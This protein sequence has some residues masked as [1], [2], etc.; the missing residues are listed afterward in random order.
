MSFFT[1]VLKRCGIY[2]GL[3][4]LSVLLTTAHLH[5]QQRQIPLDKLQSGL[6]FTGPEIL[7]LQADDF[8]N[9]ALPSMDK[10]AKLWKQVAG[11][12]DKSCQSC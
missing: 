11:K 1:I 3:A 7:D 6:A 5:A 12:S 2:I 10:G 4:G 9:P 8:A